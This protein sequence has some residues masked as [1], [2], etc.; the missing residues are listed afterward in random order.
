MSVVR[1]SVPSKTMLTP[2]PVSLLITVTA[3]AAINLLL[4]HQLIKC[5]LSLSCYC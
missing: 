2:P 5:L 3:A 4:I 1:Q